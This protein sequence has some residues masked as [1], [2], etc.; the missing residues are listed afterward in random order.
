MD[1]VIRAALFAPFRTR[2]NATPRVRPAARAAAATPGSPH[3]ELQ[4][5]L[6]ALRA[7]IEKQVRAESLSQ[8]ENLRESEHRR[9]RADGYADGLAEAKAAAAEELAQTQ[10]QLASHADNA[11]SALQRA[12]EASLS[13]LQSSVGEIAFAA[14]CRLIGDKAPSREFVL[15]LVEHTCAQLR[16]DV[17]A[18]ARL[19]PRDIATLGAMLDENSLRLQSLQLKVLPDDS[20]KLGGCVIEAASGRYDG[21]LESQLRRLHAVLTGA[22]ASEFPAAI[23]ES[24]RARVVE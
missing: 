13:R 14:V 9:A 16:G 1:P 12:H 8:L 11:L 5:A 24:T 15:G 19:H 17:I 3:D 2:L 6:Q 21:A 23:A 20:L 18:T 22:H 7:D 4:S 10:E